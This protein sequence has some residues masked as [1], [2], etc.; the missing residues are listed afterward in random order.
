MFEELRARYDYIIIDSAPIGAVTDSFLLFDYADVNIFTIR[1]NYTIKEAL[2]SNLK[3]IKDKKLGNMSLLVNDIKLKK[4][5]YG[6]MYQSQ[7]YKSN[8]DK[9]V[10]KKVFKNRKKGKSK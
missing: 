7:Y 8:E 9:G 6:Y 1:H 4:N 10:T 3:N 2:K 5:S